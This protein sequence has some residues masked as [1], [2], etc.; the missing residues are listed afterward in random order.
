MANFTTTLTHE[1]ALNLHVRVHCVRCSEGFWSEASHNLIEF[2][3]TAI[4]IDQCVLDV[5]LNV[6]DFCRYCP[7]GGG[8]SEA[9]PTR[10]ESLP[11]AN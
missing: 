2:G 10:C 3:P 1:R 6:A 7:R 8:N 5:G 4:D 9:L 11:R